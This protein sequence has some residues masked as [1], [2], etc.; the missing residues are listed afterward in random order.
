MA[1]F[2]YRLSFICA[3]LTYGIVVYK[4]S[5]GKVKASEKLGSLMALLADE[6]VQYLL[7]ALVW[8]INPPYY[9]A[10]L[11]YGIFSIFHVATYLRGNLIP[12]VQPPKTAVAGGKPQSNPLS[13]AIGTFV[14]R[15][16]NVSMSVVATIEILIM[17]RLVLSAL[18]FQSRS[19]VLLAV[20]ATFLRARY[21]E[22]SHVQNSFRELEIRVDAAVSSQGIPPA[23][24]SAWETI[25]G[26]ARQFYAATER[27]KFANG[28]E[29]PKKSS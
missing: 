17:L 9:F 10:L 11:P 24:R 15:Y 1:R 8:L 20:F 25:K 22:S 18:M 4:T 7:L 3:A 5:R 14:K 2:T 16:Y 12:T 21:A 28:S 23:V 26:L 27:N 29:I 19:W 13:D 6:N